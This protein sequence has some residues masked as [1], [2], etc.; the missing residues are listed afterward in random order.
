MEQV[1]SSAP[2]ARWH[3]DESEWDSVKSSTISALRDASSVRLECER[4][5]SA[6]PRP[7]GLMQ[8]HQVTILRNLFGSSIRR[9]FLLRQPSVVVPTPIRCSSTVSSATKSEAPQPVVIRLATRPT[10][11]IHGAC[12]AS[13]LGDGT[14]LILKYAQRG[15]EQALRHEAQL[16]ESRLGG[17]RGVPAFYGLFRSEAW[18]VMVLEDGGRAINTFDDLSTAEKYVSFL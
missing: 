9:D 17:V 6:S 7:T 8:K 12:F 16:Y 13:T 1:G 4:L 3:L 15:Q 11:G 5:S 10:E 14:K 18:S 2:E